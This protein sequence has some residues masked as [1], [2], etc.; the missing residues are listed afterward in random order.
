MAIFIDKTNKNHPKLSSLTISLI[1][2]L[3]LLPYVLSLL[4]VNFGIHSNHPI[5]KNIANLSDNDLL[6][7]LHQNITGAFIHTILEWSAFCISV[8]TLIVSLVH[9]RMVKNIAIPIICM[10][11]FFSGI[12]DAFHALAADHLVYSSAP[13]SDFIPFTWV[14][15]RIFNAIIMLLCVS[16][17]L[18]KSEQ[19]KKM[20]LFVFFIFLIFLVIV[21][22]GL[23]GYM[24]NSAS[25]P[26]V[27]YP[28]AMLRRPFDIVPLLLYVVGLVIVY[29]RYYKKFPNAFSHT[30][31]IMVYIQAVTEIYITFGSTYMYDSNYNIAHFLK[32]VAYIMPF[33]GLMVDYMQTY[34]KTEVTQLKLSKRTEQ[35]TELAH[36]DFLTSLYNRANF[37]HTLKQEIVRAERFES[38][39]AVLFI[40]LDDFKKINDELG[41]NIGDQYLQEVAKRLKQSVRE[42]DIIARI[43]GDEFAMILDGVEHKRQAATVA[44]KIFKEFTKPYI[45]GNRSITIHASVGIVCYPEAGTTATQLCKHADIAMYEAK[46]HGKNQWQYFTEQLNERFSKHIQL[47]TALLTALENDEFYLVYQPQFNML[48]K[49]IIGLEVLL[50]WRNPTLGLVPPEIFIPLAEE[51]GAISAIGSWLLEQACIQFKE[52]YK[53]NKEQGLSL[54]FGLNLSTYQLVDHSFLATI[55][56]LISQY[57]FRFEDFVIELTE[58]AIVSRQS[59][60]ENLND[61]AN[62][63]VRIAIDDFGTG[64]SSLSYLQKLPI[65]IVKIDRDF[66]AKIEED[67]QSRKILKSIIL[68]V[69]SLE[70]DIVAE[71]V[72]TEQQMTFLLEH[73]CYIGQGYYLAKPMDA[74]AFTKLL[75]STNMS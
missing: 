58:S 14:I 31:L 69:Q 65:Q 10:A 3:T 22:L 61:I 68:M 11:L 55:K 20:P 30:L 2:I 34:K 41:H 16:L 49:K 63:G 73:G 62:L 66:V 56:K 74:E 59:T 40:D 43:G 35:L 1:I 32:L 38:K 71:G 37:E 51:I 50:R 54:D 17:L 47:E 44:R 45:I 23:I 64:Y 7:M 9:Y 33:L 67:E 8:L 15:A 36:Y 13:A 57:Q 25:L 6:S 72:E 42:T 75:T 28:H 21:A 24:S 19:M 46:E 29:P 12:L 70:L 39:F 27:L 18:A 4:G 53:F 60:L 48:D 5:Q 26:D 52:W